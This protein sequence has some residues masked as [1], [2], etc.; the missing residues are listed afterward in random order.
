LTLLIPP[1]IIIFSILQR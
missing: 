1:P